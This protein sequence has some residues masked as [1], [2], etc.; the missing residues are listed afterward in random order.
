L[1]EVLPNLSAEW[2]ADLQCG[3]ADDSAALKALFRIEIDLKDETH[4]ECKGESDRGVGMEKQSKHRSGENN[5]KP[6]ARAVTFCRA[7]TGDDTVG[8]ILCAGRA[9][10]TVVPRPFSLWISRAPPCSSTS[11]LANGKPRPVPS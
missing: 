4:F 2:I 9:M 8:A 6:Q 7:S 1:P 3:A 10:V 5:S 11:D